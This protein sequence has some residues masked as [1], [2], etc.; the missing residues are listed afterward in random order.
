MRYKSGLY[1][2]R[3]LPDALLTD[4]KTRDAPGHVQFSSIWRVVAKLFGRMN[5]S[6]KKIQ[7]AKQSDVK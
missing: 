1:V 4:P 6:I 3:L 5:T 7:H 2:L